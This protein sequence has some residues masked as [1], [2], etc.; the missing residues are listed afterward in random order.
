[1]SKGYYEILDVPEDASEDEIKAAYKK[2]AQKVHPDKEDG[3]TDKF[4]ALQEAY[5]VLSNVDKRKRYDAGEEVGMQVEAAIEDRARNAVATLFSQCIEE[6]DG[7]SNLIDAAKQKVRLEIA[8]VRT[9]MRQGEKL[10]IN[11]E[12][13]MSRITY[14]GETLNLF[15]TSVHVKTESV[16][17][18][19]QNLSEECEVLKLI[20][21]MLSD[22]ECETEETIWVQL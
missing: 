4:K 1:M 6:N 16:K 20:I 11:L 2:E 15:E 21:K 3:C 9:K 22:Y 19:L 17:N 10:L 13:L 5:M 7:R 8:S 18:T 14:S 12:V